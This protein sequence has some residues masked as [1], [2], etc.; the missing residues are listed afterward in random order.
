[1]KQK[2]KKLEK[3]KRVAKK[4]KKTTLK[5]KSPHSN[6]HNRCDSLKKGKKITKKSDGKKRY[7]KPLKITKKLQNKSKN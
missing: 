4:L 3:L 6:D 7:K 1:M 2:K 5:K